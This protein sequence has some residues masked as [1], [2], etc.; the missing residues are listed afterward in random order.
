MAGNSAAGRPPLGDEPSTKGV[1]VRFT[2]D[3]MNHLKKL[4]GDVPVAR[5][6]KKIFLT[7]INEQ[8]GELGK[9]EPDNPAP[10]KKPARRMT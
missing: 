6:V 2:P 7:A 4:A 1:Q 5:F 3:E 10:K 8:V 9:P